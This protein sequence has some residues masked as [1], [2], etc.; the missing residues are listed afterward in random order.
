MALTVTQANAVN[1]L[2]DWIIGSEPSD[3]AARDAAADL[4]EHANRVLHAGFTRAR[5][6]NAWPDLDTDPGLP[7]SAL[8]DNEPTEPQ[9]AVQEA[10]LEW[11]VFH[12]GEHPD[13]CAGYR[14][15]D[16]Q[17]EAEEDVQWTREAGTACRL[18]TRG[19]WQ[20]QQPAELSEVAA[21]A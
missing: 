19:P 10:E 14:V 18:V 3:S 21:D 11:C 2:L 8:F 16:D 4:A 9:P 12:G 20:V 13:E 7:L 15:F 5:V 6:F 1:T 17:A